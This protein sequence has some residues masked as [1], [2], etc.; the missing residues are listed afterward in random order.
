MDVKMKICFINPSVGSIR[1]G[2]EKIIYNLIKELKKR[3]GV[4]L[5]T[6]TSDKTPI[7]PEIKNLDV[8]IIALPFKSRFHPLAIN[9]E[10]LFIHM[11]KIIP[12][13]KAFD[14]ESFSLYFSFTRNSKLVREVGE[15]DVI[16]THFQT[17]A[18]LFSRLFQG[19]VP[20]VLQMNGGYYGKILH[21]FD[22]SK[23]R[24]A[25]SQYDWDYNKTKIGI[26]LEGVF[27]PAISSDILDYKA[28]GS[29]P[30]ESPYLLFVGRLQAG[31]GVK[32]LLSV[33]KNLLGIHPTLKLVIVGVG[34][35]EERLKDK[36]ERNRITSNVIFTGG[37][38]NEELYRYYQGATAFLFP[39][40]SGS[41]GIV[42]LEAMAFGVPVV[43]S[44]I[45]GLREFWEGS[46]ILLPKDDLNSWVK[47]ID[48]L[49]RD[50]GLHSSLS[51]KG[52]ETAKKYSWEEKAKE[53]ENY[54]YNVAGKE[55]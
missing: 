18:I 46:S 22:R 24:L 43:A 26:E 33:F 15:M 4:L 2:S 3:H 17:D 39:V 48:E 32:F 14:I 12:K 28:V 29:P 1:G 13:V 36:V 5:V 49:I 41:F 30:L 47:A 51:K 16:S 37:I 10:K 40:A 9:T 38:P 42:V 8:N 53:Y 55:V 20:V 21:K 52:R 34:P 50:N 7:L 25:N 11:P 19:K 27:V 44:D 54:L 23:L 6:G 45:P 31:K 35:E